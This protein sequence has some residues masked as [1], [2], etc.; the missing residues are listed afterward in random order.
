MCS[1][2][3]YSLLISRRQTLS[4]AIILLDT[5]CLVVLQCLCVPD[6]SLRA[7]LWRHD[8]LCQIRKVWGVNIWRNKSMCIRCLLLFPLLITDSVSQSQS[9][10]QNKPWLSNHRT[11][12]LR[13]RPR[14][15]SRSTSTASTR[16][17]AR[18]CW[19]PSRTRTWRS[20]SSCWASASTSATPCCTPSE[21]KWWERWSC[22]S[23]TRS[24]VVA[25]RWGGGGRSLKWR[26][27]L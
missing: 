17:A 15:T 14:S 27:V 25:C 23:I 11:Y 20:S 10:V 8:L 12:F 16:W 24:P 26:V 2:D 18:P 1:H 21:R 9:S 19:S 5:S 22:C 13:R 4:R 7:Q 6:C 3:Y